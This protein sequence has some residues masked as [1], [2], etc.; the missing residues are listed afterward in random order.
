M[1][2]LAEEYKLS[3]YETLIELNN[4]S[5]SKVELVK[6]NNNKIYIKKTLTHYNIK[7][8]E[9]IRELEN[10]H[11][12]K[13]YELLEVNQS[14]IVIEEFINGQTL[15][16]ILNENKTL[17]EEKV[18]EYMIPLCDFLNSIHSLEPPIIHRDIKP[19]NIIINNDGI[20]KV[21]DYD[22][23]RFYKFK[24]NTDTIILGTQGYAPPEQFGFTQTDS[25]SDIY[26]MGVLMNVLL[27]GSHPNEKQSQGILSAIIEKCTKILADDRYQSAMELKKALI[28]KGNLKRKTTKRIKK[29]EEIINYN[30]SYTAENKGIFTYI[31]GFRTKT[32]WKE[33]VAIIFYAFIIAALFIYDKP[34]TQEEIITNIIMVLFIM[35]IWLLCTNF[36]NI[37]SKLPLMKSESLLWRVVGHILYIFIEFLITGICMDIFKIK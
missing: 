27:T 21:I 36:M 25:R 24:E 7:V 32:A 5:K 19:A 20:L 28:N 26:S 18:I 3:L 4:S 34:P 37:K 9:K 16:E 13:I 30:N 1:K 35:S 31:P 2:G 11:I 17:E 6:D 23:S 8:Y 14:L 22:A 29:S 33:A 15:E 12:P 10:P